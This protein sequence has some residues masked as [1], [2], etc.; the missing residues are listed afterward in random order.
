MSGGP[1][2]DLRTSGHERGLNNGPPGAGWVGVCMLAEG[3]LSGHTVVVAAM[4][5][6]TRGI[7]PDARLAGGWADCMID[8]HADVPL[9]VWRDCRLVM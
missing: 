7:A 1:L 5:R 4:V 6:L 2:W 9:A 8:L 3:A